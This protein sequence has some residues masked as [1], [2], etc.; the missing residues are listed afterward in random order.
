M[1]DMNVRI[2]IAPGNK[3]RNLGF[4]HELGTHVDSAL[5]QAAVSQ[6]QWLVDL[7]GTLADLHQGHLLC[8]AVISEVC[9]GLCDSFRAPWHTSVLYTC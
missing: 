9:S 1:Q 3:Q 7:R 8:F 6:Q 4:Y 2:Q 5:A